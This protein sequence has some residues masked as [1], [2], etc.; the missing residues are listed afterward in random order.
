MCAVFFGWRRL[1]DRVS[2]IKI[3]LIGDADPGK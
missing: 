2:C 3:I 1:G